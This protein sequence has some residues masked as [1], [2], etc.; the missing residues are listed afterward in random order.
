M[1]SLAELSVGELR[2][3]VEALE[4]QLEKQEAFSSEL[5]KRLDAPVPARRTTT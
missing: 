5:L 4:R 2:A 3:R 1:E